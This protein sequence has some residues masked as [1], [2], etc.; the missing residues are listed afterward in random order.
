MASVNDRYRS[1]L[2]YRIRELR[3]GEGFS[4]RGL[5]SRAGV[6]A[7]WLARV[8]RDEYRSPDPRLLWQVA[9]TLGVEVDELYAAAGFSDGLPNFGPYLRSK[10]QLS[11]EAIAQLEA[12]FQLLADKHISERGNQ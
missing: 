12:H 2:G 9:Q 10:Y 8:E 5:A 4:V 6:D 7:S 11:D 3:Q 1:A